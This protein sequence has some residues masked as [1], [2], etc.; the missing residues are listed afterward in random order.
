M[1]RGSAGGNQLPPTVQW[2]MLQRTVFINKIRMLQWKQR[3]TIG[4]RST[5]VRMTCRA[6]PLWLERQS[7]FL[8]SFVRFTYQLVQLALFKKVD[9]RPPTNE[10]PTGQSPKMSRND[11]S[12]PSTTT[13]F[14]MIFIRESLFLVFTRERLFMIFKFTF[15]ILYY[16][17]FFSLN[18]CV[19]W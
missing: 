2:G 8:L 19:G 17:F 4:R 6:F 18:G 3:N 7:S 16:I 11:D 10:P 5:R 12:S 9:K 14:F 1:G 13:W 15:F